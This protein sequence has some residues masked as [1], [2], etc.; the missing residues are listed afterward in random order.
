MN[1]EYEQSNDQQRCGST[2][3]QT[4]VETWT[5]KVIY[6]TTA[7]LFQ[8]HNV[9]AQFSRFELLVQYTQW[10]IAAY[11]CQS[12][13]LSFF[14]LVQIASY[15]RLAHVS[16]SKPIGLRSRTSKG[17]CHSCCL[18]NSIKALKSLFTNKLNNL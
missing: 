3:S 2:Q 14:K 18:T 15:F 16:E 9:T 7:M 11:Q 5:I 10:Y 6:T 17:G 12:N 13:H 8:F 4:K 1:H